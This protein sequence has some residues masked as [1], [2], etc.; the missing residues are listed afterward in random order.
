MI[1]AERELC[2]MTVFT[3]MT[4]QR[5]LQLSL[6]NVNIIEIVVKMRLRIYGNG[7]QI[8]VEKSFSVLRRTVPTKTVICYF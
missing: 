3:E 2:A 7:A 5:I 8:R 6:D 4:L 1:V